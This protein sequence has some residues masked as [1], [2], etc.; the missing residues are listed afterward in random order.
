MTLQAQVDKMTA[1]VSMIFYIGVHT[2]EFETVEEC[3]D[4]Q[5]RDGIMYHQTGP[6][7]GL[8]G[9]W[10]DTDRIAVIA[11]ERAIQEFKDDQHY[12]R[13]VNCIAVT[14]TNWEELA[15]KLEETDTFIEWV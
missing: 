8:P 9:P 5:L 3:Y 12:G 6:W 11:R 15:A 13:E 10:M 14:K 7:F 1:P 4:A 2:P